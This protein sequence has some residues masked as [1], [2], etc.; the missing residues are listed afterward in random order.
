MKTLKKI[1]LTVVINWKFVIA[2]IFGAAFNI[3]Q[4]TSIVVQFIGLVLSFELTMQDIREMKESTFWDWQ[5]LFYNY[6]KMMRKLW[7]S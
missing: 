4:V 1:Y 5:G 2:V 6:Y 3:L 7:I